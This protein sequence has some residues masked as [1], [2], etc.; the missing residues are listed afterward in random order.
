MCCYPSSLLDSDCT[1]LSCTHGGNVPLSVS[2]L[3]L[4]EASMNCSE[5]S[6]FCTGT[7]KK[8]SIF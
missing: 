1:N 6:D 4:G 3:A 5:D 2:L 8:K 7:G